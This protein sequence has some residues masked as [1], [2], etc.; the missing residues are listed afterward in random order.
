MN[1]NTAIPATSF[2]VAVATIAVIALVVA[3]ISM[4]FV[5]LLM[6]IKVL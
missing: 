1:K 3:G 2:L 6:L 5:G 4:A